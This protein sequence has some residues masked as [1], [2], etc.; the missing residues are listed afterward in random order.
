SGGA[1]SFL[2]RAVCV[3]WLVTERRVR[4][5]CGKRVKGAMLAVPRALRGCFPTVAAARAAGSTRAAPDTGVRE[6]RRRFTAGPPRPPEIAGD[7]RWLPLRELL[8]KC[9]TPSL[10]DADKSLSSKV[11]DY[12]I[13]PRH[14]RTRGIGLLGLARTV[15]T[16]GGPGEHPDF[17]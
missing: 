4:G 5:S 8:R 2:S 10:C 14:I 13:R 9:D 3:G 15:R 12:A 11:I 1:E 7:P 17:R 16:V 6:C